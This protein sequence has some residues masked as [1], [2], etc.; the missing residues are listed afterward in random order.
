M[1]H[2]SGDS[3]DI[4]Q[5]FHNLIFIKVASEIQYCLT[6]GKPIN[7]KDNVSKKQTWIGKNTK[8]IIPMKCNLLSTAIHV[9]PSTDTSSTNETEEKTNE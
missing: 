2:D 9:C 8:N 4:E 5:T 7:V 6:F 3:G 1:T